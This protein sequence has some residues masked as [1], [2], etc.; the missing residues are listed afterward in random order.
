MYEQSWIM[1][2]I[3]ILLG[4][5]LL[6]RFFLPVSENR[7]KGS[8]SSWLCYAVFVI[9]GASSPI[10]GFV[11]AAALG[12]ESEFTHGLAFAWVGVIISLPF[13]LLLSRAFGGDNYR[14]YWNFLEIRSRKTRHEIIRF[15]GLVSGAFFFFGIVFL[16]A[17]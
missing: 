5:F 15:W 13:S 10:L 7:T 9:L 4:C 14:D 17:T 6:F 3:L 12:L 16:F 11:C 2:Q 1:T 8:V